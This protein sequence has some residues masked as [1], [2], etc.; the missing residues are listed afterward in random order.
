MII[1]YVLP[2]FGAI[3]NEKLNNTSYN[4]SNNRNLKLLECFFSHYLSLCL[5]SFTFP[6][7][8]FI[9]LYDCNY[10]AT[11]RLKSNLFCLRL[12]GAKFKNELLNREIQKEK[13][14]L[15][16]CYNLSNILIQHPT[17]VL[18]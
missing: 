11:E 3:F 13:R 8:I 14:V 15:V 10:T 1:L 6:F 17:T 9:T 7:A 5:E 12:S 4:Y 18:F 2:S 16:L